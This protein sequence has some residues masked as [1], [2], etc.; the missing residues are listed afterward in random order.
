MESR[1]HVSAGI[2]TTGIQLMGLV[3]SSL[4][5]SLLLAACSVEEQATAAPNSAQEPPD[6]IGAIPEGA[7]KYSPEQDAYPPVLHSNEFLDPVPMRGPINTAGAEDSPFISPDGSILLFFFTPDVDV[8]VEEQLL[9]SVT[10][11]YLSYR[12]DESWGQP[13]RVVLQDEGKLALDGCGFFDGRTL[14]FCSAREGYTGVGWFKADYGD[15]AW[16]NWRPAEFDPS[17]EV[18]ELH[19]YQDE[20]YFHS[21]RPGGQGEMDL[22]M[23]KSVEGVWQLPVNQEA[24]NNGV[25]DG[26]PFVTVDGRELWFT[27]WYQGTPAVYRSERVNGAWNEPE[28]IV[29]QFAGEPTLD[30]EGN[31]YFVH[32]F[33]EDGEMIEADIYIAKRK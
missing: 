8:P 21:R 12:V 22:W 18:G 23:S 6:R 32:H 26:Y 27:R 33:Y 2:R 7:I 24:L 10:G 4:C 9:D 29:S 11:I 16:R 13:E 19:I 30:P 15:G 25:S 3:Y 17:Y 14:W 5:L 1:K 20:L 28:L 31:L